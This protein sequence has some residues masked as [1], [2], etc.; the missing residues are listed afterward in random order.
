M[1]FAEKYEGLLY[2]IRRFR[3]E[4]GWT[5]SRLAKEARLS[6]N[7][8]SGMDSPEWAPRSET[9]R[10]L[11][12]LIDRQGGLGL[13]A[14]TIG[15]RRSHADTGCVTERVLDPRGID[16]VAPEF[17]DALKCVPASSARSLD[18]TVAAIRGIVPAG[19]T[20]LFEASADDVDQY[21]VRSWDNRT[22]YNGGVDYSGSRFCDLTTEP[23]YH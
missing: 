12:D 3:V 4:Q 19:A 14:W 7:A 8:L 20:H 21:V 16:V 5:R 2:A 18:F 15:V 23:S 11:L 13:A 9:L 10:A 22:G 17:G 1:A 6:I